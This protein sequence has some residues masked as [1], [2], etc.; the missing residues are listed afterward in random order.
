MGRLIGLQATLYEQ[1]YLASFKEIGLWSISDRISKKSPI[2]QM[3]KKPESNQFVFTIW[4]ST[5]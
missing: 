5:D 4:Q 3:F 1:R 2:F